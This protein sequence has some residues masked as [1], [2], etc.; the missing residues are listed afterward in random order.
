M[1]KFILISLIL[2]AFNL[3]S[4]AHIGVMGG[5][6]LESEYTQ[7]GMGLNYMP[8]PKISVGAM[9]MVTPFD[10]GDDYMIMYNAKYNIK[11]FTLVGGLMTGDMAMPGMMPGMMSGMHSSSHTMRMD[12]EPYFGIEFKPFKNRKL[13]IYYNHSDMMKSV[14]LMVP[15]LNIGKMKMNH[16]NHMDH[17]HNND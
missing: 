12:S 11:K 9:A 14:G 1:K 15:I 4:Q 5:I 13:K 8:F 16:M 2:T 7:I 17:D 10:G 6:D 3:Q